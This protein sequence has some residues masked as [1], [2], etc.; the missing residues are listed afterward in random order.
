ME[1]DIYQI[2]A[3]ANEIFSGNP[4]AVC[5]L[6]FWPDDELLQK[7]AAENNLSETAFFV[8]DKEGY[9]LRWFTP[10]SEVDLCGHA[11][12]AAAFV[13]GEILGLGDSIEFATRSGPLAV[14]REQGRFVMDFPANPPRRGGR[15]PL[16]EKALGK[17]PS[18]YLRADDHI[19]V[20]ASEADILEITPDFAQLRKLDLRG[21][22][23]TAP[24]DNCDFVSRFF[25]PK[26]GI[27]EDPVTGSAHTE[28]AP[29]WMEKLGKMT[30]HARQ[31]STRGGEIFCA[32]SGDRVLISGTAVKF[33]RG[34]IYV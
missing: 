17:A 8:E 18:E 23:V 15:N 34:K 19:A 10:L 30:M 2:D 21:V 12:L 22:A 25:A 24:G 31:V 13:C 1:I 4:A 27:F 20:F 32:V 26:L 33:M 16:L 14:R 7:I 28:L 3:F 9:R 11:T 5:P 29:Y 6:A